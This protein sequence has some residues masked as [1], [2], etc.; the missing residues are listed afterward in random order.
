MKPFYKHLMMF[1][2]FVVT[3]WTMAAAQPTKMLTKAEAEAITYSWTNQTGTYT[4]NLAQTAKD[5]YQIIALLKRVYTCD[6]VP[7]IYYA[8]YEGPGA[9]YGNTGSFSRIT[10]PHSTANAYGLSSSYT[11]VTRSRQAY[12]GAVGEGW[13]ISSAPTPA[14]EGYTLLFVAVKDDYA[15]YSEANAG[16]ITTED[17]LVSYVQNTID[18]VMLI[19]DGIRVNTGKNT[20][21]VFNVSGYFNRFFFM[22]KGQ[23]RDIGYG[24][25]L[26]STWYSKANP[27]SS[28]PTPGQY[29]GV[30]PPF[31]KMFEQFS[32]NNGTVKN[33]SAWTDITDFYSSLMAGNTYEVLHD[34]PSVLTQQHVFS[35]AGSNANTHYTIG[36][37]NIFIP[38]YRLEEWYETKSWV[39][40]NTSGTST[41]YNLDGRIMFDDATFTTATPSSS[42]INSSPYWTKDDVTGLYYTY[43][44]D[45]IG[46]I[47]PRDWSSATYHLYNPQYLPKM[48]LYT[49]RLNAEVTQELEDSCDVT[50]TWNSSWNQLVSNVDQSYRIYIVQ[51]DGTQ[52][53]LTVT[54]GTTYTYR[55]P[56]GDNFS[57]TINYIASAQP[58]DDQG[59]LFFVNTWSNEDDVL[60]PGI[61]SQSNERFSLVLVD[62][63]SRYT[64]A[65]EYNRYNNM[66]RLR[67]KGITA[68]MLNEGDNKFIFHRVDELGTDAE[69]AYMNLNTAGGE[70]APTVEASTRNIYM[71]RTTTATFTLDGSYLED[72]VTLASSNPNFSVS[73]ASVQPA[74]DGTITS[75]AITV[76]YTGNSTTSEETDITIASSGANSVTVH[77]TYSGYALFTS[78]TADFSNI[79]SSNNSLTATVYRQ[80]TTT[81]SN[82]AYGTFDYGNGSGPTYNSSH[83]MLYFPIASGGGAVTYTL[84]SDVTVQNVNVTIYVDNTSYGRGDLIVNGTSFTYTSSTPTSNS[85]YYHTWS[86]VNVGPGG[87]ITITSQNGSA[88]NSSYAPDIVRIVV[89]YAAAATLK[90][91]QAPR[92][93]PAGGVTITP[94]VRYTSDQPEN[95][96]VINTGQFKATYYYDTDTVDLWNITDYVNDVFEANTAAND[97]SSYYNYYVTFEAATGSEGGDTPGG[98]SGTLLTSWDYATDGDSKTGWTPSSFSIDSDNSLWMS[99]GGTITIP[100]SLL[101]G[102][103]TVKVVINANKYSSSSSYSAVLN[104]NNSSTPVTLPAT[105][106]A[107][108]TW[109]NV[110]AT[111]GISIT[112][113]SSYVNIMSIKVYAQ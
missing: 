21:A 95:N 28:Y 18:S 34:C 87:T 27:G 47:Y 51:E 55:V 61:Y 68:S 24:Q 110:S 108:Y 41:S 89:E 19:T 13:G 60:I 107:D 81:V 37:L 106:Y 35:M 91:P 85:C 38:D 36:G 74:A 5:P 49:L 97:H 22:T 67:N 79:S 2:L 99:G 50:L 105:S 57:Y 15:T 69:F 1:A 23:A 100:Y 58:V 53:P 32:P 109:E 59:N 80:G 26:Y 73:P 70:P 94:N 103:S 11:N 93:L 48:N 78:A 20:G 113:S 17:A 8:G 30:M 90:A 83:G 65:G 63:L 42:A 62:N 46:S 72:A 39:W 98:Q 54:N 29:F 111:N 40:S 9:Y 82:G 86:G 45:Y 104:V 33:D 92:R 112:L 76:T 64:T 3:G 6:S 31:S 14:Q 16:Y 75:Q 44:Y 71:P 88:G 12:Y 7:G 84:P 66:L 52:V 101:N 25:G 102:S 43:H 4:S 56:K 10:N 77:V 96:T